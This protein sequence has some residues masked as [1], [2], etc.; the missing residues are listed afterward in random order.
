MHSILSIF[1]PSCCCLIYILKVKLQL[2]QIQKEERTCSPEN[3][4]GKKSCNKKDRN[5]MDKIY[6]KNISYWIQSYFERIKIY[7]DTIIKRN[8]TKRYFIEYKFISDW[9]RTNFNTWK[10]WYNTKN[11]LLNTNL[12]DWTKI[13]ID[14]VLI[15]N[16]P[17]FQ[18]S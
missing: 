17:T 7:F 11:I 18:Q 2:L 16:I 14:I 10:K 1:T 15:F 9:M 13:Y 12:F 5:S 3:H 8:I 6:D 4:W